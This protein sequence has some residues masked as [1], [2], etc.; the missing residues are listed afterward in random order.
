MDELEFY[1]GA[2][3]GQEIDDGVNAAL[4]PETEAVDIYDSEA[5]EGN[6]TL[7]SVEGMAETII[8][9]SQ[10][11]KVFKTSTAGATSATLKFSGQSRYAALISTVRPSSGGQGLYSVL[12]Y[13][14]TVTVTPIVTSSIVSIAAATNGITITASSPV[15]ITVLLLWDSN[16]SAEF[17]YT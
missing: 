4:N 5:V 1:D 12:G 6:S 7:V 10:G 17:S 9:T 8:A 14:S 2:H 13:V 15:G 11:V 3:T 16:N